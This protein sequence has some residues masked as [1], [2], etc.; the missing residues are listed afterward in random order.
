MIMIKRGLPGAVVNRQAYD[1]KDAAIDVLSVNVSRRAKC[2]F[3][4]FGPSHL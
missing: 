3:F 4:R 1:L 2:S